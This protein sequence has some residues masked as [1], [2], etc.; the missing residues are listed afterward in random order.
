MAM[1]LKMT[2]LTSFVKEEEIT[3]MNPLIQ[4]CNKMLLE[5]TGPGN[6]FLGWVNL[7]LEYD[8]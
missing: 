4:T 8:K 2:G 7:P 3:N 5:K 6:D 1:E